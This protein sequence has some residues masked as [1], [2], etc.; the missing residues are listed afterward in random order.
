MRNQFQGVCPVVNVPFDCSGAIDWQSFSDVIEY[1]LAQGVHTLALFAFNSEPHKMT[2]EEKMKLIPFFTST[3]KNRVETLIGLVDNSIS[4]CIELG[5]T[6]VRANCDGVILFPPSISTPDLNGLLNYF[7]TIAKE[8]KLPVML[9]DNPRSTGVSMSVE[10]LYRAHREIE[11]FDYLK[12]ECPIP[13]RK[14]R[15]LSELSQGSLKCYSGNGGIYAVEAFLSGAW[16]IMPGVCTAGV[17]VKLLR[18]LENGETN[19]ARDVFERV[20]PLVW[21]EDQSLEFYIACEK[22]LLER[23]S[24]IAFDHPRQPGYRLDEKEKDELFTLYDRCVGISN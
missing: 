17:Y 16:G 8:V 14:I 10:L 21:Y 5:Q 1:T 19:K 23:A 11:N 22:A 15:Q 7:K 2:F 18:Y 13:A 12:V 24:A 4:G 9:Q 3:V 20:L 6:A